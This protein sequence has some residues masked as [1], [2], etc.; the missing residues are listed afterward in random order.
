[1]DVQLSNMATVLAL[2]NP[3]GGVGK[4]TIAVALAA[5]F[6][7]R[8]LEVII[9]DADPQRTATTWT[10]IEGGDEIPAIGFTEKTP[11]A[12]LAETHD[13]VIIDCPPAHPGEMKRGEQ[14]RSPAARA[15]MSALM[16]TDWALL[17]VT[18][19]PADLWALED[20]MVLVE[21]AKVKNKRLRVASIINR[22]QPRTRLD[23][24]VRDS[25][26]E[27]DIPL[28]EAMLS[29]AV[30]YREML[31]T[32]AGPTTWNGN[33]RDLNSAPCKKAAEEVTALADELLGLINDQ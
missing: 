3:K 12:K 13:I 26:A 9:A 4:T 5:E 19:S 10:E 14:V 16:Q 18:A 2:S 15:L 1:M 21:R 11:V 7:R 33:G 31:M 17:P 25:V 20:A 28:L 30:I 29:N 8:G 6:K 32:G 27:I 22:K 23:A 24:Q